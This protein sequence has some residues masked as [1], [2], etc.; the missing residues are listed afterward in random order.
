[1]HDQIEENVILQI[2]QAGLD[3]ARANDSVTLEMLSGE[4]ARCGPAANRLRRMISKRML[5]I[6]EDEVLSVVK[7]ADVATVLPEPRRSSSTSSSSS[8]LLSA[9]YRPAPAILC[10]IIL[11]AFISDHVLVRIFR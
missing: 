6:R 9:S 7:V 5:E 4:K 1:M 8:V 2:R 11:L 10:A 3:V